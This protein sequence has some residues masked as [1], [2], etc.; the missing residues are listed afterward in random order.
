V[1]R[2]NNGSALHTLKSGPSL[3]SV[4]TPELATRGFLQALSR[5]RFCT[6][7]A[8]NPSLTHLSNHA[9]AETSF[10]FSIYL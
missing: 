9:L 7:L 8:S 6:Y 2:G 1:G 10:S 3:G 5:S 4:S